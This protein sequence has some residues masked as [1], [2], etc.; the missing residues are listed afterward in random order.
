MRVRKPTSSLLPVPGRHLLVQGDSARMHFRQSARLVLTC[1][2][3]F[4]PERVASPHGYSPPIHDIDEFAFWAA[5]IL[6]RASSSLDSYGLL[7]FVKTDVRYKGTLLPVGFRIA[8]ALTKRGLFLRA[9][10]VWQRHQCFSPYSP[11]TGNIFVFAD[12]RSSRPLLSNG[13]FLG[14]MVTVR[15]CQ[16]TS[17][18]P[19][20]FEALLR[21][22]SELGDTVVDPFA[23]QGSLILAAACC[24]RWSACVE[25]S[26][27]QI[28]R[29]EA[30][31]AEVPHLEVRR[32]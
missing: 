24:G 13:L 32:S 8:D 21:Q 5:E 9:H 4:H 6:E 26:P 7:C 18:T 15:R 11:S 2:P 22:L 19:G 17:F 12:H 29:A 20:L 1:P 14:S 10:W 3:F 16:P 28:R 30:V 31:L 25:I 27:E 23:G